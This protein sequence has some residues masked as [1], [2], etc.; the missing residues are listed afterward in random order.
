LKVRREKEGERKE[1]GGRG[2]CREGGE[3]VGS[4][5]E[6]GEERMKSRKT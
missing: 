5:K 3:Y 1:E 6:E 4:G 2:G